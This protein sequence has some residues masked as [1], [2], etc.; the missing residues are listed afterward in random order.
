[1]DDLL[2]FTKGSRQ[3]HIKDVDE[4]FD[5]LNKVGCRTVLEKCKFFKKEV[6]FLGFVVRVNSIYMDPE[7]IQS[8]TKWLTLKTVKEV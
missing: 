2:I 5:R 1:M 7:K 8:I 6:D 3:Q 4:V